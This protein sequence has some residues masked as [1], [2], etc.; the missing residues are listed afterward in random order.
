MR[1][2]ALQGN[3]VAGAEEF[4]DPDEDL[5]ADFAAQRTEHYA[6]LRKP[7]DPAVFTGELREEMCREMTAC[8]NALDGDGLP[9]LE[10]AA[11]GPHGAIRL[12]PLEALPEPVSWADRVELAAPAAF[13]CRGQN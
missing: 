11:R 1:A 7:L 6:E 13:G 4:R 2:A 10:V 3:W 5:V 12:T 8:N 9:W